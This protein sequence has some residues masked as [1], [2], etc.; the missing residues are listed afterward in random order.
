[1]GDERCPQSGQPSAKKAPSCIVTGVLRR[2][3][4]CYIERQTHRLPVPEYSEAK[5]S[6]KFVSWPHFGAISCRFQRFPDPF[7]SVPRTLEPLSHYAVPPSVGA[8]PPHLSHGLRTWSSWMQHSTVQGTRACHLGWHSFDAWYVLAH[9]KIK[10]QSVTNG[11]GF[12]SFAA[13]RHK[14]GSQEKAFA[15]GAVRR[16]LK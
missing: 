13:G 5:R 14:P 11:M 9:E 1:M 8:L 4:N 6:A 15:L 10:E 2:F 3:S 12:A 7:F 16:L